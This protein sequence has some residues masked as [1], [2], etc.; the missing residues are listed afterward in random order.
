MSPDPSVFRD[1]A[2]RGFDHLDRTF[3]TLGT[4]AMA[5]L[6]LSP[7]IVQSIVADILAVAAWPKLQAFTALTGA[8]T[9]SVVIYNCVQAYRPRDVPAWPNAGE[10]YRKYGAVPS[11]DAQRQILAEMQEASGRLKALVE[12]RARHL[13]IA[14]AAFVCMIAVIVPVAILTPLSR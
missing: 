2:F 4:R 1:L 7:F 12:R 9:L 8:A 6:A 14:I 5:L 13:R 3:D 11:E 10:M